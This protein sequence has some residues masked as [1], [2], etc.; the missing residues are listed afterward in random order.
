[1]AFIPNFP[2]ETDRLRLRPFRHGDVEAVFAYRSREDV[3]R[4]LFDEAMTREGCTEAVCMRT[5]QL[6]WHEE[7]D[8]IVVAVERLTD[9]TLV[10]EVSLTLRNARGLQAELGYILH[11][12][13][14]GVGYATEAAQR[15]VDLGFES[16]HCHR[17]FARC[18]PRNTP[19]QRVMKRL[20]MRQEAHFREHALVKGDWSDELV[21]AILA[22]EWSARHRHHR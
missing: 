20:G 8:R 6:A 12:A 14:H 21:F 4:Y 1:M 22:A 19:S 16:G 10:G 3:A 5:R 9:R 15:L 11:P 17:I 18:D 7:G 2:V 13:H